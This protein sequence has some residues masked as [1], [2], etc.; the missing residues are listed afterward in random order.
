MA[1][2]PRTWIIIWLVITAG[3]LVL[4]ACSTYRVDPFFHYHAPDTDSY[5]YTLDNE[6]S[7]NDGIVKHFDY[8][9][10]I[11]GSSMTANFRTSEADEIFGAKFI[12][13]PSSGGS[14]KE[15]NGLLETAFSAN[16]SI[17]IVIRGL[18]TSK[19][20]QDKDI[21]REDL[22]VYPD[23][24]YDDDPLNDVK[25][26][27][28]RDVVFSRTL[29]MMRAGADE[30][31]TGG[32]MPFDD[33]SAATGEYG[34]GALFPSGIEYP[35][36]P[37]QVEFDEDDREKLL[38][39][40]RQNVTDLADAHPDVQF[41]YFLT[42]YSAAWWK[43]IREQGTFDRQIE[44]EREAVK[45]ILE[46]KNIKL[47]SFSGLTD[48]T[49]DLNNYRDGSHYGPWVNS[50]MLQYMHDGKCLL[51]SDNYEMHLDKEKEFYWSYDYTLLG[52]QTDY[53][54]DQRAAGILFNSY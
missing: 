36:I 10:I 54:D 14:F 23:Y 29:P 12:K 50:L 1:S 45:E 9:G 46:H 31:F 48:I 30:D 47:Y 43:T 6:R 35:D 2:R 32:V 16:S 19:L 17:R 15:I 51:T 40:I 11:T 13:I 39:N 18:D 8:D 41:Y 25:Y 22:G 53:E 52:S 34:K 28:N 7:Q 5:Y 37:E 49:T 20:L 26:L 21:M 38:G 4:I 33:Y 27:F 24:L 3:I 42:P 44:A